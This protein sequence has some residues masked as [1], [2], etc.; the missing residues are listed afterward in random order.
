MPFQQLAIFGP[1]LIGGSVA[2][3]AREHG[4]CDRLALWSR[5]DHERTAARKLAVADVITGDPAEAVRGADLVLLCTPPASLPTLA[6]TIALHL[7]PGAII[8]DVASVKAG[9]VEE[10]TEI[11]HCPGETGSRFVGAHPM[12]GAE[13]HGLGAARANLF[14]RCVCLLTPLANRTEPGAL[15]TVWG[16]WRGLGA[17]VREMTPQAH[18]AAVATVSHL[19][20]VL[21]A[22][23]ASLPDEAAT[24]CAGP[25]WR[26]MTRL[27]GGSPEL[28]TEILSHNR[29]P[30]TDALRGMISRLGEVLVLLEAGRESDLEKFLL[31]AKL[32][33]TERP[34]IS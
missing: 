6:R 12:A 24:R 29:G 15:E 5:D 21:A 27:A 3:A 18:D 16:F 1:G 30:V 34:P 31:S 2:L 20:H 19:P 14:E 28:W 33:R 13:R 9:L 10:L 17:S 26:D 4:L 25:G 11:F 7:E 32:R 8:S 23:L 22:A